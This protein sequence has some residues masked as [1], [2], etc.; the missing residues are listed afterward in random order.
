MVF[1]HPTELHQLNRSWQINNLRIHINFCSR[2]LLFLGNLAPFL[3]YCREISF[4]GN[5]APGTFAPKSENST[6]QKG[7]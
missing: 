2:E 5:F 1:L 6:K 3:E 4:Q 7:L